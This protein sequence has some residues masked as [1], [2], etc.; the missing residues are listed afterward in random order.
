MAQRYTSDELTHFVGRAIPD[1]KERYKVFRDI[2]RGGQLKPSYR[3]VLGVG[4]VGLADNRKLISSNE[5]VRTTCVCFCDIPT[6]ALAVHMQKYGPFGIAFAKSFLVRLG[7]TPLPY[8]EKNA[9]H[10]GAG[11]LSITVG[12]WFDQLR[13]KLQQFESDLRAYVEPIEGRPRFLVERSGPET[14][15]GHKLMGKLASIRGDLDFHVL[16][17]MKFFDSRLAENDPD[18]F[19]MEREWRVPDSVCFGVGQIVRVIMPREFIERF[20]VEIR[21]FTGEILTAESLSADGAGI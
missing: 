4:S 20:Q 9:R 19:Y 16:G 18:N 15:H 14:L 8:V 10:R 17:Q 3:D 12:E 5:A 13:Q 7:A 11:A 1:Y 2:V 21:E 6:E